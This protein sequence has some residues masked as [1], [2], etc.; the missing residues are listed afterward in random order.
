VYT[1][2]PQ[3]GD[4]F[5]RIGSTGSGLTTLAT[6]AALATAQTDLDTITG[7]D[8]VTLASTQGNS[9]TFQPIVVTAGDAIANV[10]LAGS[11]S[12]DG[13]AFTRS[14]AGNLYDTSWAAAVQQEA[15]DAL[16]AYDPPTNTEMVAAFTEIKGAT[17]AA[18]TD[19]LELIR[20]KLTDI[21]TDT[22]EIG[23]AGAGLTNINLPNQT[24]DIVG[25]ITGNLSGSV[26]SVTA[27]VSVA[28]GGIATTSFAAG[29]IDA[30]SLATDTGAEIADAIL[31]RKLDRTGTGSDVAQ[32]RTV[33]NALRAIRN[34]VSVAAGTATITKEDDS[35]TAWTTAIGT[36]AGD[37]ISSS[38]PS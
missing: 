4:S 18:G 3:T 13:L 28:N 30:A 1:D 8:G 35:T 5:A 11:G 7:A 2:F 6:A 12:A 21:E 32:E 34:K 24:M 10:T 23:A 31:L 15:A 29:A 19:T 37:P 22:A 14:G 20:D 33:V 38:D 16:T 9:I 27:G 17:W 26:G 25:N 36:T